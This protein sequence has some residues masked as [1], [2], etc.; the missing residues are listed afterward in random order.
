MNFPNGEPE[1]LMLA[2]LEKDYS[3]LQFLV[4]TGSEH[5]KREMEVSIAAG[6]IVGLLYDA[7]YKQYANP[8][9]EQSLKSLNKL[10]VRLV[11]CLYVDNSSSVLPSTIFLTTVSTFAL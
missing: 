6:E 9:A 2:D 7:L 8:Q 11:F 4:D 10:C 1:V 5:L 3:R